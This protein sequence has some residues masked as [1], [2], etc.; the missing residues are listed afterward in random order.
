MDPRVI[1][2]GYNLWETTE[3]PSFITMGV[4]DP[5]ISGHEL[6]SLDVSGKG[7]SAKFSASYF[8]PTMVASEIEDD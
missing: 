4:C 7:F 3:E 2:G 5:E 8:K 6:G 1:A